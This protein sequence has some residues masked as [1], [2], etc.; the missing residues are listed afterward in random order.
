MTQISFTDR[1]LAWSRTI[2][3]A[4]VWL[5]SL[6]FGL[7]ILGFYI[8]ELLIGDI[9]NWNV[10]LPDVYEEGERSATAGITLHFVMG[11][12]ILILGT[13][14]FIPR[15]RQRLPKLHRVLGRV[16]V[17]A[18]LLTA[19]GGLLFIIMSGT[20][21]GMVM[22]IAFGLYGVLML[23]SAVE[24]ARHARAKRLTQHNNWAL[25][26]YVLAIGSWLYRMG[27]GIWG[28]LTD[29]KWHNETLTGG[30]DIFMNFA[31]YVPSLI[32]VEL[33][34]R[35]KGKASSSA[36]KIIT[37][38]VLSFSIIIIAAAT[39]FATLIFWLPSVRTSLGI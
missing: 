25:R 18:C 15:I 21:G 14:Q 3:T 11:A 17:L 38:I 26:L 39:Y 9:A 16:Y 13:V 10:T 20:V 33:M 12:L 5:S 19:I 22:N 27:H 34:I 29:F 35:S 32:L 30:F 37:S 36:L 23:V 6:A 31:F 8:A 4:I 28:M 24:T 7:Y 2:L 1:Y